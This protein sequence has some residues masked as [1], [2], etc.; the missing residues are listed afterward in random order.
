MR[1]LPKALLFGLALLFAGATIVWMQR[2]MLVEW[3]AKTLLEDKLPGPFTLRVETVSFDTIMVGEFRIQV[4]GESAAEGIKIGID[5]GNVLTPRI[6]SVHVDRV[7][8]DLQFRS[9]DQ[10]ADLIGFGRPEPATPAAGPA[11]N[12]DTLSI[13]EIDLHV[14]AAEGYLLA[15]GGLSIAG[16][17]RLGEAPV[18]DALLRAAPE[19]SIALTVGVSDLRIP[20]FGEL[21][22]TGGL[23]ISYRDGVGT[24]QSDLP[25]SARLAVPPE[26]DLPFPIQAGG[27][28]LQIG[29][30]I[31]PL[32]ATFQLASGEDGIELAA[33]AFESFPFLIELDQG[34]LSGSA[35]VGAVDPAALLGATAAPPV[36]VD[37][38]A[39]IRAW[40]LPDG[41][42]IDLQ[43][44]LALEIGEDR[45]F[46]L[47]EGFKAVAELSRSAPLRAMHARLR[48]LL[49]E[50]LEIQALT[51]LEAS[52]TAAESP[53]KVMLDGDVAAGLGPVSAHL[54]GPAE[55]ILGA[56]TAFS[57]RGL[58][59]DLRP[60]ARLTPLPGPLS[61][62]LEAPVVNL[63][64]TRRSL[65]A[66]RLAVSM[67]GYRL[68]GSADIVQQ[69][70][71]TRLRLND[72]TASATGPGLEA[73]DLDLELFA[74]D[75]RIAVRGASEEILLGGAVALKRPLSFQADAELSGEDTEVTVRGD[76]AGAADF[77]ARADV[78]GERALLTFETGPL[79]LGDAGV[80]VS[81]LTDLVDLGSM[82]PQGTVQAS[83]SVTHED[84]DLSGVLDVAVD[85]MGTR[86]GDGSTI[87]VRGTVS[88]DPFAFPATRQPATLTGTHRSP[89]LGEIPFEETFSIRETGEIDLHELKA[90]FLDGQIRIFDTVADPQ[91]GTVA[92]EIFADAVSLTAL[93]ELLAIDGLDT[94][95]RITGT[96]TFELAEDTVI[97]QGGDLRATTPGVLRYQGETL[98]AAAAGDESLKLLVQALENFHYDA[99]SLSI[100]VPE[101]GEGVIALNLEGANPDVL[102][103][104]PFDVTVN[105]ESD[106]GKLIRTFLSLYREVDLILQGS[107]R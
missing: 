9:L 95:G 13:D 39:D 53:L 77:S 29:S 72:A 87:S 100:D 54:E 37:A 41:G 66:P 86:L 22:M 58:A 55:V 34:F 18:A 94:T 67:P 88:F 38:F 105:L 47:L 20:A 46:K 43:G 75:G 65:A 17:L 76:I 63:Q 98:R 36:A 93:A 82:Q 32:N 64:G 89:Y 106:Y 11:V 91:A 24:V 1:H 92:G 5:W 7:V 2:V 28:G 79:I 84:G 8:G 60:D 16:P 21:S 68:T 101:F 56:A 70:G 45:T 30:D 19:L 27:Y 3:V 51:D 12:L 61:L 44:N 83:G 81:S 6:A 97:L 96:L 80:T 42:H 4:Y 90:T 104:H 31:H 102:D 23:S 40:P 26:V 48:P 59:V 33:L 74:S 15:D 14:E 49:E 99:L 103:G 107:V 57:S 73:P 10:I 71:N 50:P 69:D 78:E 52:L 62:T 35:H 25:P 85:E